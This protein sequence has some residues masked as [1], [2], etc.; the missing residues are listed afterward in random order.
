MKVK[1]KAIVPP[2]TDAETESLQLIVRN[3][4]HDNLNFHISTKQLFHILEELTRRRKMSGNAGKTTHEAW[5]EFVTHY[6]PKMA[7]RALDTHHALRHNV[8]N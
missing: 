6:C 4:T 7:Q 2:Y 5:V 1:V 3:H 8:D